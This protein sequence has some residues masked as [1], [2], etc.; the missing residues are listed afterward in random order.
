[1]THKIKINR[2]YHYDDEFEGRRLADNVIALETP[3]KFQK[4]VLVYSPQL[5][6]NILLHTNRL[7]AREELKE[8]P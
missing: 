5:R 7:F 1:M 3:K 6:A 4:K 2:T 8:K